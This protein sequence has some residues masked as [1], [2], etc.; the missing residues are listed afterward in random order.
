MSRRITAQRAQIFAHP[1]A[2]LPVSS[3][4][5]QP[6]DAG[7]FSEVLQN[8]QAE[9]FAQMNSKKILDQKRVG[10]SLEAQDQVF[11]EMLEQLIDDL[12]D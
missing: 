2:E 7:I 5:V 9:I 1:E 12:F 11:R 3:V 10:T 8:H 6:E 4:S